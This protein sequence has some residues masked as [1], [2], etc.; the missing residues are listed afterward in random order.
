[1]DVEVT[2]A[3]DRVAIGV[4]EIF[5]FVANC[6]VFIDKFSLPIG[7]PLTEELQDEISKNNKSMK[8][9]VSTLLSLFIQFFLFESHYSR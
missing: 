4:G 7:E 1:M 9:K 6:S 8:D 3:S 2:E 5:G